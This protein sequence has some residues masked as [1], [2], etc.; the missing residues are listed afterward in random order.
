[1][2]ILKVNLMGIVAEVL[3]VKSK[4]SIAGD[5]GG[6]IIGRARCFLALLA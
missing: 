5:Y 3:N 4:A 6:K 2:R 1:M